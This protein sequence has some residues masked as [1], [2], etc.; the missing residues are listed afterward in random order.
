MTRYVASFD[1]HHEYMTKQ[2]FSTLGV[3]DLVPG[4]VK[5]KLKLDPDLDLL[6]GFCGSCLQ[7]KA[8]DREVGVYDV[9]VLFMLS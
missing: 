7:R 4:L 3:V 2:L 5:G 8:Y 1:D 6:S 9:H